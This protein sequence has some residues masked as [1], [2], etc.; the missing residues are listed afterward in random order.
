MKQYR[1]VPGPQNIYVGKGDAKN[2]CEEFQKIINAGAEHGWEFHSMETMTVTRNSG[3]MS[4]QT[5]TDYYMLIFVR[6]V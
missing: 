1:I 2:A 5:S 3:C 4:Q 6:D